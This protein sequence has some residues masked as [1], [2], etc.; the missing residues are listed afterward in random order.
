MVRR[1]LR[2]DVYRCLT[3]KW[4][5]V[6]WVIT[7]SPE[8]DELVVRLVE[9]SEVAKW[10][11]DPAY[12]ICRDFMSGLAGREDLCI[13]L[14]KDSKLI[15]YCFFAAEPTSIDR[16][17]GFRFPEG[18]IYAYKAL[19]LPAWRGEALHQRLFFHSFRILAA[20][21]S[22]SRPPRGVVALVMADNGSSLR[23]FARAGFQPTADFA[24]LVAASCLRL[25]VKGR[26]RGEFAIDKSTNV[27]LGGPMR[28]E[29]S[30][31]SE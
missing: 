23:A 10:S 9:R 6:P 4:G 18:W 29:R 8:P 21:W 28:P 17:L 15:S 31:R 5:A 25:I 19:T 30:E 20:W 27:G 7:G 26:S 2:L 22:G 24:V 13:G 16:T 14:F 11:E 1:A 3:L 12:E